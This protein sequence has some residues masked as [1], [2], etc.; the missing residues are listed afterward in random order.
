LQLSLI[1][2]E[3]A[4]SKP[5]VEDRLR[6]V[7]KT[8][9][10]EEREVRGDASTPGDEDGV[11]TGVL[12]FKEFAVGHFEPHLMTDSELRSHSTGEL[13]VGGIG[14]FEQLLGRRGLDAETAGFGPGHGGVVVV[15]GEVEEVTGFVFEFAG[16]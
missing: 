13:P 14:D 12:L 5:G 3:R 6:V 10:G 2:I 9:V 1:D 16:G 8:R 4:G 15:D 11:V 7:G